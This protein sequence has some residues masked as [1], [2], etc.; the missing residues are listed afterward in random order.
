MWGSA[1]R[2][3]VMDEWRNSR[4]EASPRRSKRKASSQTVGSGKKKKLTELSTKVTAVSK[5][6]R[7]YSTS[8]CNSLFVTR[9]ETHKFRKDSI[10][11][12]TNWSSYTVFKALLAHKMVAYPNSRSLGRFSTL[13]IYWSHW[14]TLSVV[15]AIYET[16]S[17][18]LSS[19]INNL[20][21]TL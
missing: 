10:I 1:W 9:K 11:F 14:I 4:L 15:K 20:L 18:V 2:N 5:T 6:G 19:P 16:P 3:E 8:R 7:E 13:H 12:N 21:S 17:S